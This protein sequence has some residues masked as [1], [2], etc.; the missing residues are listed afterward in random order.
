MGPS[1]P[2]GMPQPMAITHDRNL[3]TNVLRLKMWRMCVPFRN[4]VTSGIPEPAALG[5][6][7]CWKQ[8]S[9]YSSSMVY[10]SHLLYWWLY[11]IHY[12]SNWAPSDYHSP[13]KKGETE[14]GKE[15]D[16][17]TETETDR[18]TTT[19]I[20][21]QTNT[22]TLNF[23]FPFFSHFTSLTWMRAIKLR[24]YYKCMHMC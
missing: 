23:H 22:R 18:Q 4:P 8:D 11:Y 6:Q 19:K 13:S 20:Q 16:R 2:T 5:R 14:R 10:I 24:M 3:A 21:T 15:T 12:K 9:A 17:H 1:G 7:N